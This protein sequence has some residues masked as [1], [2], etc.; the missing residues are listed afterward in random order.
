M[1]P[2]HPWFFLL[3]LAAAVGSGLVAGV[4][5]A[6]STFVMKALAR[7]SPA[8][9][10]RAMQQINIVVLNPAF[11]GVFM[12][13][14]VVAAGVVVAAVWHWQSPASLYI[15][16]GSLLYIVGTFGVTI[17][18]NVPLNDALAKVNPDDAEGQRIWSDYLRRWTWWNHVRTA[19]AASA[20]MLLVVGIAA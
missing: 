8:E 20:M 14:V 18:G 12:G 2:N 7:L 4:F 17:A 15:I 1:L 13:T 5:F 19:A 3:T 16:A 11:L 10:I 9:G 6:F